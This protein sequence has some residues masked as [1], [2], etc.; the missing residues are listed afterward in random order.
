VID[1]RISLFLD[2]AIYRKQDAARLCIFHIGLCIFYVGG[3]Q[4]G[5]EGEWKQVQGGSKKKSN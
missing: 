5:E 1:R 2:C 4:Q 3:K